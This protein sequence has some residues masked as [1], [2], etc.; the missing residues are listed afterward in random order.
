M[1]NR[2][3]ALTL[4]VILLMTLLSGCSVAR[5]LD[6]AEDRIENKIDVV[7]DSIENK[8]DTVEDTIETKIEQS[9]PQSVTP[10]PDQKVYNSPTPDQLTHAQAMEIALN[11]SG[12]TADQVQYLHTDYEIDDRIPQYDVQFYVDNMEYEYEIHAET[13]DILSY[14]RDL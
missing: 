7:E 13:G 1:K 11:H 2:M 12:F 6:A 4:A 8:I 5:K 9:V 10:A 14:D 3:F